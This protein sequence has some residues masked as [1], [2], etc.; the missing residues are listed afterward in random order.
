MRSQPGDT[1]V[2][3]I[4]VVAGILVFVSGSLFL[5]LF[6]P[7]HRRRNHRNNAQAVMGSHRGT[8]WPE[9]VSC[10]TLELSGASD[11]IRV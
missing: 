9:G 2:S 6:C 8:N 3:L 11:D 10:A 4:P 1:L 5:I 7:A